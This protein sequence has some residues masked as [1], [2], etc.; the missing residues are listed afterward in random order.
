MLKR[1]VLVA[2]GGVSGLTVAYD[3]T[4]RG[5][6]CLVL[7]R[8]RRL[9]GL[10]WTTRRDGFLMDGGPDA[11]LAAKRK[12]RELVE[13]LGL[14]AELVPTNPELRKVYVL[15]RGS[16]HPMPEGMRLT[17]P[18]RILP[19]LISSLFSPSGKLRLLAERFVPRRHGEAEESIAAFV[20]RRFGAEALARVGEPLL[21]GIHCGDA[22]RL[23]MDL[24]FP[25]LVELERRH[26]SVTA[27]MTSDSTREGSVFLSLRGGMGRLVD[28]L[29]EALPEG[30][31]RPGDAILELRPS[32]GGYQ[33]ELASGERVVSRAVVLALPLRDA[34][35]V[36]ASSFPSVAGVLGRI[37]TVSTAVVFHAFAR[38]DVEHP[39]DGYGFVVPASEPNRLLA[40]T[41]V[42]TK[43]P[44]RAPRDTV[45]LRT[46]LGGGR[47][48][49]AFRLSEDRLAALSVEELARA[50]GRLGPPRFSRVIRWPERTPQVE[51]GHRS[52]VAD[53]ASELEAWPGLH[54]LAS[55]LGGIGIPD[56]IGNA[57]ESAGSLAS[58]LESE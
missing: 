9:G 14:E 50:L 32:P 15:H 25:R 35:S 21:A 43:F 19:L 40:G 8:E 5:I 54:V 24:L 52:I 56:S 45:L 13:E 36:L 57:R 46:F 28:R 22:A 7:E 30:T 2:G 58:R 17:V 42:S 29:S 39:L 3:L 48:P 23:S 37:P 4:R 6:D 11:F 18:T 51:V 38:E 20:T 44:G 12:G 27:G 53:L 41:F 16:L 26:G 49:E 33:S 31:V 47:D 55:G 34:E 1:T 10:I